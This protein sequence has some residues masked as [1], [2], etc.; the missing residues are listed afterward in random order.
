M[1][2]RRRSIRVRNKDPR[3]N[4][5]PNLAEG[6]KKLCLSSLKMFLAVFACSHASNVLST[7]KGLDRRKCSVLQLAT[8]STAYL[9][10]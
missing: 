5:I 7:D 9:M 10:Q 8:E 6:M 4:F 3:A 2:R 1:G